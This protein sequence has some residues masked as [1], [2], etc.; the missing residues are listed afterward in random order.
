MRA[1]T[2]ATVC[3]TRVVAATDDARTLTLLV[4]DLHVPIRGG[5]VLD[6]FLAL[7]E[8]AR[9]RAASTRVLVLG[10]LLESVVNERQLALGAWVPLLGALRRTTDAGVTVTLLH[11]NRD[12]MLGR[13]FARSTGVR[14]VAGGLAF[15][16]GGQRALALHGDELCTNDVPYQ[17]SKRWLR[18]R[19]V[20]WLCAG[21]PLAVAER[22]GRRARS[23]S[24]K[25]MA[26]GDAGRFAPVEQAVRDAFAAG[27]ELLVFGHVH[28]PAEGHLGAGHYC[29]LPA[30][31]AT[32]TYLRHE[33]TLGLR[34]AAVGG[35]AAPRYGP[36]AFAAV[37]A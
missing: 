17:R 26:R 2:V 35:R 13:R 32:A 34:F 1:P 24:G 29:I 9:E 30:F 12:F 23:Q 14:V 31:D 22:I 7:L 3:G 28:T 19:A 5:E 27:F 37:R 20:R 36:L 16:V 10:D 8:Q 21:M 4:S 11:G 15:V 18:T 33:P 6:A 25:S